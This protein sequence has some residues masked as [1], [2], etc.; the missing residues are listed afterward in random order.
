MNNIPVK[1]EGLTFT[2]DQWKAIWASG[3]D[4]LVSAAAGSGKTKV[5]ITR[6]IEKVINEKDRIDIDELLVV[7]FTNAAA[8]EMRHRMG[9][10]LQEAIAD[11]PDSV[12]LRRQLNLLNKAQIS[13]LHSFCQNVVRQYAYLLDIDPGF[14]VA[15]ST[16]AAL[17][18]DDTI[19]RVLEEAY[20]AEDPEAIYRLADSFTSDRDD[21]SIETLISRLY[22][23]SRVHPAPEKW[24]RLIPQQ[25]A[26]D[27]AQTI[28]DL[29]FIGPLKTT[30]R[31]TLEEAQALTA[32][33]RRIAQMPDG[34]SPLEATAE[35]DLLWI[36][37]AIRRITIGKWEETFEFF[38]TLKWARAG[39]IKKDSCDEEL[40]KRAKGIRDTVKKIIN[41][42]SETYFIRTP[43]RLLDEIKLMEPAMHTLVELVIDFDK[44]FEKGKIERGIVDFS[45]LEHYA[46]RI[47][48]EEKDG[49]LVASDIALDYQRRF[50]EV[51]VDEYQDT[52]VLQE[53]IVGFVKKGNVEDGNLFMVGDV[54]QSIYGFRLAEPK[55]F[56]GKYNQFTE[57]GDSTGLKIDLNANFRS[58]KEVLDATNFIFSQVMGMRVGD[59]NYDD[60]AEL[61]YGAKYPEKDMPAEL[62]VLYEDGEDDFDETE[63]EVAGQTLK[64]SQAEARYMINKIQSL[65]ASGAEVTDAFTD[66]RRPLEY[67]DIVILMRSMT[68]S[69]EI[70]EEFK[71]AGIPI[72][73]NLSRGYFEALEVMITLNTLRVIDN[74]YQ[75]IPLASVLR[76]PFI[77]MTENELAGVRLAA[78]NEPF[79]E[80]LK[81]FMATGGSGIA[82]ETQEKLQ[83]FFTHFE[84]W[85]NLAR[86]GSLSDL[87][88]QVYT[89]THYYEMV[90]AM[91][92]GKQR[93]ANLRALHDRAIEYE[94]TSFRGLFRFLR[95]VDRMRK[96][97]DDLGE[98]RSLTETE[99]VVRLMTI[100]S[101]KG[102]EFPYVFI[103]G[104][105]RKFNKM[106]FNEAYL[107]DQHFGLAVKAVDPEKRITYTSLPFLAMKEKKELEM[108][109]E[110]MR[111][112]YVA[113]TRAKEHLELIA[114]VK[115]VEREIGKWQ[116]SQLVDPLLMLPEYT[117][118][119]ANSYLDWIGPA[120]ARHTDFGKFDILQ[121]GQFVEDPSRWEI[122]ALPFSSVVDVSRVESEDIEDVKDVHLSLQDKELAELPIE[123]LEKPK[124]L[125]GEKEA[126]VEVKRRFDWSYPYEASTLKRSKQTVS[127]L[128]RLA[129]LG[130]Q[131]EEDPYMDVHFSLQEK[132]LD[133]VST[134][135]LHS[136]P[137]FMQERALSSAEIGTAMHTIMQH[138]DIKVA[139][140]AA[141]VEELLVTLVDRQLLTAEEAKAVNVN[142]VV[143]FYDTD[144]A[145]R[146]MASEKV[147]RELPFTYAHEDDGDYQIMQ[148][149]ADCLFKEDDGWVLLDYKTDRVRG[150]F[151]SDTEADKEMQ[152][153]YGIQ[154]NL[155]RRAIEGIV[156]IDIK[157]MVL[158]LFDGE[159]TVNIQGEEDT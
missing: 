21:R 92:N 64:S 65:M 70:V 60:A 9:E 101:S 94:K 76:S 51:L 24:L 68:W 114:T 96:R 105:G 130:Q 62:T 155:Y 150:R 80:A 72:Y 7:T 129:I 111:I 5:L 50:S 43:T 113:M 110:E 74:P 128:K 119:R 45:D 31:H 142:A 57:T 4:I 138:I 35:A 93:Q 71:L 99:D 141:D 122:N 112:L 66:K 19:G 116:D 48:S 25:Y 8:A 38:G 16:E 146:L 157:E 145:K 40:A 11:K 83:R 90:G 6:M 85:R 33:M 78:K 59:I 151:N 58:R 69:G 1:P 14:R 13:T 109:A 3:R 125:M 98:A 87:I 56:L 18:R 54:K 82:P 26:I 137:A 108:R 47:L 126:L 28:D 30:I 27:S 23:Y 32:D 120:I 39:A 73:A 154:L 10:A 159:R 97:G 46:L 117:R 135:Y 81:Q 103:S 89:D 107:F 149:I 91:P 156:K 17:L 121:G 132:E 148:G 84:E 42:L 143:Q 15:D 12:H 131:E 88:W 2:D 144:I 100:H 95:F 61:K 37:E 140:N 153:Q 67:R 127:E 123:E 55:L 147:F 106:D 139:Q 158:Y 102:L 86:R 124:N 22:D 34:P 115:D 49:E 75:D 136:R 53:T 29:D 152:N 133:Q 77:G 79:Y 44:R 36:D 118:S 134:A 20:S 63:V 104:M 52:N 41:D